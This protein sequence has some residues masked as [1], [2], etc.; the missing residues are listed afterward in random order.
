MGKNAPGG[1]SQVISIAAPSLRYAV[2]PVAWASAS[3]ARCVSA[4]AVLLGLRDGEA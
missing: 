3:N 4:V 2:A 1:P